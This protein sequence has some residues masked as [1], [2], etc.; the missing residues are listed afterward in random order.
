MNYLTDEQIK[1][2]I[3]EEIK[4]AIDLGE[5]PDLN[6]SFD[7]IGMDSLDFVELVMIVEQHL[8]IE[9]DDESI[10]EDLETVGDFVSKCIELVREQKS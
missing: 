1:E 4:I 5:W 7:D 10:L 9:V 6:A 2:T 3:L 8:D